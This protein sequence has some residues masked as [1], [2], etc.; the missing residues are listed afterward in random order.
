MASGSVI[1]ADVHERKLDCEQQAEEDHRP[2]L[3][4]VDAE[5]LPCRKAVDDYD[6]AAEDESQIAEA[7]WSGVFKPGFVAYRVACPQCREEQCETGGGK[8]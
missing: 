4:T 5:V 7:Q 3:G 8:R 2:D 1:L 6:D